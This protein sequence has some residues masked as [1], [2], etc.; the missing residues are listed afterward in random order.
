MKKLCKFMGTFFLSIAA[1]VA[2]IGPASMNNYAIE[3]IPES[4]QSKR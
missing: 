2:V 4:I 3:E 1:L